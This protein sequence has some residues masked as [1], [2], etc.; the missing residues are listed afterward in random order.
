ML[1]VEGNK[2]YVKDTTPKGD[3]KRATHL[4]I[5]NS[6]GKLISKVV[7]LPKGN[8]P[9]V[10]GEEEK[11][12]IK[13]DPCKFKSISITDREDFKVI[14]DENNP[15]TFGVTRDKFVLSLDI[16]YDTDQDRFWI[17]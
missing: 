3:L 5:K 2:G 17:I 8:K 14:F 9:I 10:I 7:P 13:Y 12:P 6:F 4:Y 16:F 1:T 15:N 11:K